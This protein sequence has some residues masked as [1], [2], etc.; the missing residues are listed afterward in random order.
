[1]LFCFKSFNHLSFSNSAL[2]HLLES[3]SNFNTSIINEL[4]CWNPT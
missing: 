3:V 1:M 4:L 2:A